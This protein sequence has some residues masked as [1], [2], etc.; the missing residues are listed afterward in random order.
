M[1]PRRFLTALGVGCAKRDLPAWR[2]ERRGE[3]RVSHANDSL[4][5]D[6]SPDAVAFEGGWSRQVRPDWHSGYCKWLSE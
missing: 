6:V 5:G 3:A 2:G 1:M 4:M